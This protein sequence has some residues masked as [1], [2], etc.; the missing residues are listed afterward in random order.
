MTIAP[1]PLRAHFR[2]A[3][4]LACISL[5]AWCARAQAPATGSITGRVFNPSDGEYVKDAEIAVQGTS[6]LAVTGD[7]GAY[8]LLNVPAGVA[9]VTVSYTGFE[10]DPVLVTVGGGQTAMQNFSLRPRGTAATPSK[11]QV[12]RLAEFGVSAQ[13]EGNAKMIMQQKESMNVTNIVASETFGNIAEG[14]VGNFLQ[15]LPAVTVDYVEADPRNPRVRGLPAQYTAV[16]YN[17]MNIASADGF[18]QNN[19]TDNGGGAGA[20]DRSFGFEQVSMANIDAV[21]VNYTTNS[22]Q[23]A[24]AAAGTIDLIPRHAFALSGQQIN[25]NFSA[26]NDSEERIFSRQFGPDDAKNSHMRPNGYLEYLNSF[27]NGRLGVVVSVNSAD[28]LHEQRQFAPIYDTTPTA[29]DPR[30][31]VLTGLIFKDGPTDTRR[32]TA[33]F[34]I[35]FRA[36]DRLSFAL[37][38]VWNGYESFVGNRTFGLAS[39][40]ANVPGDSLS[41]WTNVPITT[42]SSNMSYLNK[43]TYGH[44]WLPS[45]EY[46]WGDFKINGSAIYSQS[47]NN[48]SGGESA[49]WPGNTVFGTT[50]AT[51]GM[52]ASATHPSGGNYA[53]NYAWTVTQTGGLDFSN[54]ANYHAAATAAPQFSED[55]RY[56]KEL[57]YQAKLDVKWTPGWTW[58]TWFQAGPKV[59]EEAYVYQ[60]VGAWQVW[61]YNGPGGGLGGN[62][63]NFPS[64]FG[65]DPGNGAILRS[66]TGGLPAVQDHNLI[67]YTFKSNP[68]YFTQSGTAANYLT[69]FV[70]NP[71]YVKEQIDAG[72]AMFDTKPLRKLEVQ[73][74]LREERTRDELRNYR[75]LPTSQVVAAGF[76]ITPATGIATT[77]PGIQYQYFSQPRSVT[78]TSYSKLFPSASVKYSFTHDLILLLGYSYTVTRPSYADLSGA[79]TQNDQTSTLTIPNTDLK[80]QYANNYSAQFN[81]YFEPTGTLGVGI[82]QNSFKNYQQSQT[83]G[84]GSAAQFGFDDPALST[85]SVT[86]KVNIPGTVVFRGA[87]IDYRQSLPRPFDKVTVFANYTRLYDFIS[88]IPTATVEAA[89]PYNYGWLPGVAPN[90]VNFGISDQIWRFTLGINAH[91]TNREPYS[92]TFNVWQHQNTKFSINVSYR[93]TDHLSLVFHGNNIF[94]VPDFDYLA[95]T[96]T[97]PAIIQSGGAR[98]IEYYGAYFYTGIKGK[99]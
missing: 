29:A 43:R 20:A 14:N 17:G 9:T 63:Q 93:L 8:Q 10:A 66:N 80:P 19:G 84:A 28:T 53:S 26:F 16:T 58:P 36:T 94:D 22:S 85:Y 54:L 35:D 2:I 4:T 24:D 34:T 88:G 7:D 55:G 44:S 79:V 96:A 37:M 56:A 21:A 39:T 13:K 64:S 60:N 1:L 98:G 25:F 46:K 67:G 91:W 33:A 65:F 72:Y 86:T 95:A 49:A 71:R 32:Q 6:L 68:E 41:S 74:G 5:G 61:S 18:I 3:F 42:V 90:I 87:T 77:I 57:I 52:T 12:V 75:S 81:Y 45:F 11:E 73:G 40:R 69:A 27:F 31:A 92:A 83:L 62:W 47:I 78:S 15:Y 99:F 59:T 48:Y 23:N 97:R 89:A 76:P 50:I 70:N 82:F 30:P 51:T 38:G